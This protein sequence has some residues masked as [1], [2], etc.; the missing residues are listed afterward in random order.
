MNLAGARLPELLHGEILELRAAD[1]RILAHNDPLTDD[2]FFI[3]NELH[4]RDE[5]ARFL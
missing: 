4:L 5:I 1:D 2:D 3:G